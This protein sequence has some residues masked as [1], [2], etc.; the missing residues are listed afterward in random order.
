MGASNV[1]DR[2]M[3][4]LIVFFPESPRLALRFG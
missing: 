4:T 2:A 1:E 3:A